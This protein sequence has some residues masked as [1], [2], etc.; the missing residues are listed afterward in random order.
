MN[1]YICTYAYYTLTHAIYSFG[2]ELL[3]VLQKMA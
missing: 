3:Y 2:T 1:K